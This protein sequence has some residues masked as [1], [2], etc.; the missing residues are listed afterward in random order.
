MNAKMVGDRIKAL[1]ELRGVKRIYLAR[2]LNMS[3]NTLTQ[4]LMGNREFGLNEM[5]KI[6][7]IFELDNETC[8]QLF[9]CDEFLIPNIK[10][11]DG[12]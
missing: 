2:K 7:E 12:K 5:I 6:K 3:Y 1:M 4:K 9:F 11:K 8:A 10:D